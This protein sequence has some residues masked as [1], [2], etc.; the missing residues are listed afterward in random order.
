LSVLQYVIHKFMAILESFFLWPL[1]GT[2]HRA[3]TTATGIY[4]GEPL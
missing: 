4:F 1:Q 2:M 3:P